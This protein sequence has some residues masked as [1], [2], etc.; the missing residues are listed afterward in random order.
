MR[1]HLVQGHPAPL[2]V[3]LPDFR[4]AVLIAFQLLQAQIRHAVF[5]FDESQ[6]GSHRTVLDVLLG[7][8]GLLI[9]P[10]IA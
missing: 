5:S 10:Q 6:I 4:I 2:G 8:R 3:S 9:A 1:R 7:R